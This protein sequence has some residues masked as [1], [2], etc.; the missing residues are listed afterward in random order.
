MTI[1]ST[2]SLPL[3]DDQII[4]FSEVGGDKA[5]FLGEMLACEIEQ[6]GGTATIVVDQDTME[7]T[8]NLPPQADAAADAVVAGRV[9]YLAHLLQAGILADPSARIAK[10]AYAGGIQEM[11]AILLAINAFGKNRTMV[12][13]DAMILC[14]VAPLSG[15]AWM[16]C[17]LILLENGNR[18]GAMDAFRRTIEIDENPVALKYLGICLTWSDP[19]MAIRALE[20]A[21]TLVADVGLAPDRHL[22][23][24]YG[25][26]LQSAGSKKE[27]NVQFM[28]AC[29][30]K[31]TMT[32]RQWTEG[33]YRVLADDVPGALT[34]AK[35]RR[36]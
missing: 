8:W 7:V 3:I 25:M 4:G 10:T 21:M 30:K 35:W 18:S 16:A 2:I 31:P 23:A 36:A 32:P 13:R 22:R 14:L 17:G 5:M 24:A 11:A 9:T 34:D 27:A 26:A 1:T 33:G 19:P 6:A 20:R 15:H 29:G 28:L 12:E